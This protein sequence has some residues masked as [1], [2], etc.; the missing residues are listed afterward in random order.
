MSQ[1]PNSLTQGQFAPTVAILTRTLN[2]PVFLER[3]L[4][5]ILAQTRTDW[6]WVV[7]DLGERQLTERLL[8][9]QASALRGRVTHLP[10]ANKGMRG[11][12]LNAGIAASFSPYIVVLDDDD[13]WE[14]TFLE[15]MLRALDNKPS[16]S[17]RGVVCRTLCIEESSVASGLKMKG[18]WEL[19]PDLCQVSLPSLAVV[20]R[21]CTHA[22]VYE[23]GALDSVGLCPEDYPVLEDWHLNLR[24]VL[25]HE[26]AVVPQALTKYH[27]RP[28]DVAGPEANSQRAERDSHKFQEARLINEAIRE[29]FRSGKP[30]LGH[31]LA[32]AALT[33][34]TNDRLHAI[35]S[36]LKS[37][38][39]KTGKIDSRTKTLKETLGFLPGWAEKLA[40][41]PDSSSGGLP[42]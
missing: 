22:F 8:L 14:P 5:S 28:I 25:H 20:N 15:T 40:N 35:E 16:P 32:Q 26:I 11:A 1:L 37:I 30:G 2:R 6:H 33:R 27:F 13:T 24:F 23:R 12:A 3:A 31:L 41:D 42:P 9:C 36:R 39:E 7:V 34:Q 29:D 38:S 17:V 18:T 10:Y 21:F 19:N 4:A